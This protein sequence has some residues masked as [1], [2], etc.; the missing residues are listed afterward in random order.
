MKALVPYLWASGLLHLI[1]AGANLALPSM[2]QYR[3]NLAS[4]SPLIR[5]IFIVHSGYIVLNQL[6]F[7]GLC[8]FFAPDLA[9]GSRLG[10]VLSA[11]M[12]GFW[13][14]RLG[15]QAFY[16]DPEVKRR[17]PVA[18]LVFALAFAYMG[19]VSAVGALGGVK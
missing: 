19:A 7:A 17:H 5:Q 3:A 6:A 10:A 1:V 12:A 4:V 14:V 9:G 11:Y 15:V 16:Y 8:L 18:N 13:L 2:L